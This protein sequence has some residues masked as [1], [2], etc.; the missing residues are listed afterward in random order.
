[1]NAVSRYL[2]PMASVASVALF[3]YLLRQTGPVAVLENIRV[4]GWGVVALILLSAARHVLR[5][6][7][8][9]YCIQTNGQRP[10]ALDLVG[11]RLIGEALSDLTPAGPLLGEP[12]KVVAVSRLIP[13][14]AGASSVVIENLIYALA[15]VLFMVSG[16]VLALV[17]VAAL[18][19]LWWIGG[20]L[21][22]GSLAWMA[23]VAWTLNRRILL[24]RKMFDF[25]KRLGLHWVFLE[26]HE[27]SVRDVEHTIYEFFLKS[28][29]TFLAVL[30]IEI[31]I[32]FTG[33]GEAYL[34]LKVTTAHTSLFAA[35]LV[36]SASRAVQLT[37]SFVPLGLGVQEGA[38]AATLQAIGYAAS[39]GVS[40]SVIRKIRTLFW[41]AIGLLFWAKYSTI[42]PGAETGLNNYETAHCQR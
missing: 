3:V 38:A 22:I 34:I 21:A 16:L 39:E 42:S 29:R 30:A 35:Y 19:S 23:L 6:L 4:V 31:A 36:E 10:F 28:R 2:R 5:A 9:S 24:F 13:V 14:E 27:Q 32:N 8:W 7:G 26:R 17:D 15:A 33:V 40:L 12:A 20:G 41:A 11:P 18:R 1:M 37:F 25:L